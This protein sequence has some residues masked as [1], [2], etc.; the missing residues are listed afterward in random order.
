MV[1]WANKNADPQFTVSHSVTHYHKSHNREAAF[2][3]IHFIVVLFRQHFRIALHDFTAGLAHTVCEQ[4]KK[5]SAEALFDIT[6]V[7]FLVI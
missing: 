7:L 6:L 4:V 2:L 5:A 1:L 3:F